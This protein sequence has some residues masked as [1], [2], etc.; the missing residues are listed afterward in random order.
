MAPKGGRV[1]QW[2]PPLQEYKEDI[3]AQPEGYDEYDL[4]TA[5]GSHLVVAALIA[6]VSFT[7]GLSAVPGGFFPEP[8]KG[9]G[10]TA[11]L[12]HS[13]AFQ[14]FLYTDCFAL[15]SSLSAIFWNFW[16]VLTGQK[17]RHFLTLAFRAT[18]ISIYMLMAAF[19]TG[20]YSFFQPSQKTAVVFAFLPVITFNIST[21]IN[22]W[23]AIP[24]NQPR[25]QN[26][27]LKWRVLHGHVTSATTIIA[28]SSTLMK[29]FKC[30]HSKFS[31]EGL[32]Q[33]IG[34]VLSEAL[35]L[36]FR[37]SIEAAYCLQSNPMSDTQFGAAMSILLGL[38]PPHML[39]TASSSKICSRARFRLLV[40][41]ILSLK[42]IRLEGDAIS[43]F[44]RLILA[45]EL[46]LEVL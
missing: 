5:A 22:S 31:I 10:G 1:K 12:S 34:F 46:L 45:L 13:I 18:P 26:N 35:S 32:K 15:V 28:A 38:A 33:A 9:E 7:A 16:F 2:I 3:E 8:K 27:K 21:L 30:W 17:N 23:K 37:S 39:L 4:G 24:R 44:F 29:W 11:I 6:T 19:L 42:R 14:A 20:T 25:W 43:V 41:R 36:S 40:A